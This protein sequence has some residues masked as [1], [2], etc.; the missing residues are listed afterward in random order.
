MWL[1]N[2]IFGKIFEVLF[3][4]FQS[5]SPW[6]GMILV[7]LL[8]GLLMLFIFRHTSN[9]TEIKKVKN[10]IKAHLLELRLFKDSMGISFKA[11][12]NIL[13]A[14]LKYIGF[15]FKPLLVMIIPLV[16]ILIQLNFWFAY[17]SLRPGEQAL[18]RVKL[19]DDVPLLETPIAV[20]TNSS[21][22]IETEPLRIEEGN[23]IEWRIR[24]RQKGVHEIFLS[25]ADQEYTKIISVGQKTLS[26]ISPLKTRKNFFKEL[27][28]PTESPLPKSSPIK[29]VEI[30][31]PPRNINLF[32]WRIHWLI[33]YFALSIVFGFS[34]K[35]FFGVEI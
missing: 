1:F 18:L 19:Q 16:L 30:T 29:S 14:N 25:V 35:G 8:T 27:F 28:Y 11:Q 22:A 21:L 6:V 10:K 13:R 15:S 9:Q 23:E 3:L 32:G 24:A 5:L 2:T 12:G 33:I 20:Q 7:S 31:Y 17:D 26:K 34:L 4:P